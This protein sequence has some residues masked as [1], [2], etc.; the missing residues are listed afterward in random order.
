[1]LPRTSHH[2]SNVQLQ[3]HDGRDFP[4]ILYG[5]NQDVYQRSITLI[6]GNEYVLEI[7]P[8]G[9]I[10]NEDVKGMSYTNRQCRLSHE[11]FENAS[12]PIYTKDNCLYDCFVLN[13]YS[14]CQCIPW[15]FTNKIKNVEECD[16][17]GRTCFFNM[18]E[19]LQH[20][21]IPESCN[22]CKGEC[23]WIR[24]RRKVKNHQSISLTSELGGSGGLS[25]TK[26][27][28]NKYICVNASAK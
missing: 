9:Q 26:L 25:N 27:R 8:Y 15:D 7:N 20:K 2:D 10:S 5:I 11:T 13:A 21:V 23:D 19:D 3:I 28:C 17:F 6:P 14:V 18:I 1:M 4:K 24:Y 16:I 12:H 22:H